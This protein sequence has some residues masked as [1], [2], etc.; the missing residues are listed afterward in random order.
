MVEF[1]LSII[2]KQA[3]YPVL[4]NRTDSADYETCHVVNIFSLS[5]LR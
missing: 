5:A 1:I 2:P 4:G 3:K